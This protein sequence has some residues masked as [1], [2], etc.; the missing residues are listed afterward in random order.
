MDIPEDLQPRPGLVTLYD[1]PVRVTMTGVGG[2]LPGDWV[3]GDELRVRLVDEINKRLRTRE[4]SPDV[5]E[6][7]QQRRANA[8]LR[9]INADLVERLNRA[10]R[11]I[12]AMENTTQDMD[13]VRDLARRVEALE[14]GHRHR[15]DDRK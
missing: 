4:V 3:L 15:S 10:R 9:L 7:D 12:A 11:V 13:P 1:V 5:A 6:L 2:S 8:D 14:E